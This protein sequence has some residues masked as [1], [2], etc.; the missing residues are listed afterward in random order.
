MSSGGG[1]GVAC[2]RGGNTNNNRTIKEGRR[3]ATSARS[4][5]WPTHP[6][7]WSSSWTI[8][9]FLSFFHSFY[10][11]LLIL[12][13]SE[14][15]KKRTFVFLSDA[16]ASQSWKEH[17][18]YI[19]SILIPNGR[20]VS[21]LLSQTE[22][23]KPTERPTKVQWKPGSINKLSSLG[24]SSVCILFPSSKLNGK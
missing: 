4:R 12:Q 5:T 17:L 11:V 2:R 7:W 22:T 9:F 3:S 18:V 16:D 10:C 1:G 20:W 8:P 19:F 24:I 13:E 15:K 21:L 6:W 14:K 23:I